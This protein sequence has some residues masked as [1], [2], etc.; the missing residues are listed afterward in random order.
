MQQTKVRV[1]RQILV[2]LLAVALLTAGI[3][4]LVELRRTAGT[5]SGGT[6]VLFE[7]CTSVYPAGSSMCRVSLEPISVPVTLNLSSASNESAVIGVNGVA[8]TQTEQ[9]FAMSEAWFGIVLSSGDR[10][11]VNITSN[12]PIILRILLDNGSDYHGG[13]LVS[14]ASDNP[15]VLADLTGIMAYHTPLKAEANGL[16]IFDLSVSH[17]IPV[18]TVRFDIQNM[19]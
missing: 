13:S 8:T 4:L 18:A 19:T 6:Q 14:A 10:V 11:G 1:S 2:L 5:K 15:I 3:V 16:Y 9:V 7:D 12:S 17:P